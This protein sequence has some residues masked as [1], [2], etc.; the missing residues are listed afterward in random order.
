MDAGTQTPASVTLDQFTGSLMQESSAQRAAERLVQSNKPMSISEVRKWATPPERDQVRAARVSHDLDISDSIDDNDNL[1][2][3]RP[4][5]PSGSNTGSLV[6]KESS[7]SEFW[8]PVSH[9]VDR[10]NSMKNAGAKMSRARFDNMV[11]SSFHKSQIKGPSA[12]WEY[13]LRTSPERYYQNIINAHDHSK[14]KKGNVVIQEKPR[15]R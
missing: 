3:Q 10:R 8:I 7:Q 14:D 11:K 13:S 4:S 9:V 1:V 2:S 6:H 12:M 5:R 15:W